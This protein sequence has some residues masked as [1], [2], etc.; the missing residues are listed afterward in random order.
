MEL[1]RQS[2]VATHVCSYCRRLLVNVVE[3]VADDGNDGDPILG[4][5]R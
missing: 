3:Y 2:D 4:A 1:C 5:M